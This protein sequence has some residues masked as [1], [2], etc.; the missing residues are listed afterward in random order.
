MLSDGNYSVLFKYYQTEFNS[1]EL[2]LPELFLFS[3]ENVQHLSE[4]IPQFCPDYFRLIN[5]PEI[6]S[7]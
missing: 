7:A 2:F 6:T 3:N 1:S 4:L 5:L